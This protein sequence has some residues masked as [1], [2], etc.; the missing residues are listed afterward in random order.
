MSA[1]FDLN[2]KIIYLSYYFPFFSVYVRLLG[3][4]KNQHS[5]GS[6]KYSTV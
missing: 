5:A 6:Y 2:I 1:L 3:H 4:L